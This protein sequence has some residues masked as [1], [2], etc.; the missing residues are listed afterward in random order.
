MIVGTNSRAVTLAKKI[1]S[2]ADLGYRLIGFVDEHWTGEEQF[3]QA[4][5]SVVSDFEGFEDFLKDHVVDE[6]I[7][8]TPVK[9]LYARS[10]RILAQCEQQGITVR[11]VSD[12]FTP[13]I[14]R[15]R[16][17]RFEE[18]MVF[19]VDTGGMMGPT[20]LIKRF[21]DFVV[22][23]AFLILSAPVLLAIAFGIKLNSTG[24][25][26]FI[27]E[28]VGLNKRRFRLYKF[29]TMAADAEQRIAELER[30]NEVSGP[31]FKIKRDPR[32]T[33]VGAFL[34]KTSLDELP[35]LIN[36]LKGDMSL[37][38]PRP[39]PVRDYSGFT[40]NWHRRR[41]SVRPGIT[42][43]WQVGGRNSIPFER[44]MELDME[45][46]DQW[47]LMLDLKILLKTVPAVLKGSG[48]S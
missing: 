1:E 11:F 29:R 35:Q 25:V 45:Y 31:V 14:G 7:I 16:V 46:I 2:Q 8:C 34:R 42:C 22:S 32:I 48:A 13:T 3:H 19:T 9:S 30:Y 39:L 4:G 27:Q 47:S 38:G 6:V 28:R 18:Q 43:L 36:V 44:W 24:P 10:S 20:V 15:S 33:R 12:L 26:F 41:F 37:V 21:I 40:Q 17:E 5:Y 23:M